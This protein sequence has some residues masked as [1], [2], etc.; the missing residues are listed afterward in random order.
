[1]GESTPKH[2]HVDKIKYPLLPFFKKANKFFHWTSSQDFCCYI[3]NLSQVFSYNSNAIKV[4]GT[5]I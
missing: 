5:S 2:V 3:K 4:K 1:M